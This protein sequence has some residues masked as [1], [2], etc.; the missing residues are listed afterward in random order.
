MLKVLLCFLCR[1]HA[2]QVCVSVLACL[3][4]CRELIKFKLKGIKDS[5]PLKTCNVVFSTQGKCSI[6]CFFKAVK[7]LMVTNYTLVL[8]KS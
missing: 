2:K 7:Q 6:D 5:K 8:C 3:C 1:H 4:V